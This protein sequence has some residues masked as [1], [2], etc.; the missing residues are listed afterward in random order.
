MMRCIKPFITPFWN[1]NLFPCAGVRPAPAA[2]STGSERYS[3]WQSASVWLDDNIPNAVY[4]QLNRVLD[5][6]IRFS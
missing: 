6:F 2:V 4:L 1:D 5:L 3:S